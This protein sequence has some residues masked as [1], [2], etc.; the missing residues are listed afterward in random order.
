MDAPR[1]VLTAEL[2]AAISASK[3]D[4]LR[5][6]LAERGAW[7]PPVLKDGMPGARCSCGR[8]DWVW[9]PAVRRWWCDNCTRALP[10]GR[11]KMTKNDEGGRGG[12]LKIL[13]TGSPNPRR[14]AK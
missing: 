9:A 5:G 6:L 13:C 2:R 8:R 4:L 7:A 11:G 3:A 10:L 1:G 12:S 14:G